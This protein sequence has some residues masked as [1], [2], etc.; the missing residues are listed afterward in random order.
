MHF[1]LH[2]NKLSLEGI[3]KLIKHVCFRGGKLAM[4]GLGWKG[5]LTVTPF[6]P[7]ELSTIGNG[8]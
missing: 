6:V 3:G 7:F 8:Y 5:D 2:M 1:C 4:G